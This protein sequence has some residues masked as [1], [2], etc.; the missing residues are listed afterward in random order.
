MLMAGLDTGF[1]AHRGIVCQATQDGYRIA[2]F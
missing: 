2:P 1:D